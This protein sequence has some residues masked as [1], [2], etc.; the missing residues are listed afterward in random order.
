MVSVEGGGHVENLA[1]ELE[2]LSEGTRTAGACV[3]TVGYL[4]GWWRPGLASRRILFP[5]ATL[6][7]LDIP[8]Q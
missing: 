5:A 7:V 8:N 2:E 6:P 1:L 3:T 4:T